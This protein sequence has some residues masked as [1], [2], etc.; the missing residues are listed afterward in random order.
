MTMWLYAIFDG[1]GLFTTG[2]VARQH[3]A[4]SAVLNKLHLDYPDWSPPLSYDEDVCSDFA[5]EMGDGFS[6]TIRHIPKENYPGKE[7][8]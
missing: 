4:E 1:K 8:Y 3:E 7:T 2:V 6:W 5:V